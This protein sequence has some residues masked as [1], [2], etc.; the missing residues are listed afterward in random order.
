MARFFWEDKKYMKLRLAKFL[1]F[2]I[3]DKKFIELQY[4]LKTGQTL[5]LAHPTT[6]NEKIQWMKLYYQNP[7]LRQCVDKYEVREYVKDKIGQLYLI[8]IIGM[9]ERLEDIDFSSLP[10]E[11][12]M[13]LTNGSSFNYISYSKTHE[14]IEAIK[15]NFKRWMKTD[16]HSFGRE[17][18]YKGVKNRIVC[19]ELLKTESGGAPEDYRFFCFNGKVEYIAIDFDSVVDGKK[20]TDYKRNLY[21]RN[22]QQIQGTIQYPNKDEAEV[23]ADAGMRKMV[24]LAEKL[25][26]EFPAVRVDFYYFD[27]KIYFGEL[28]FY[29]ASGYQ[30]ITPNILAEAMGDLLVL[31]EVSLLGPAHKTNGEF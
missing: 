10:N 25:S 23:V 2:F 13:K 17:W 4:R 31:H 11:F 29:H 7:L 26:S 14:D 3:S 21:D 15:R 24:Q 12:I 6:Y 1:T 27:G 20:T 30:K 19:E 8:P 28:T 5:N 9:H 22:W 16:Y 18:A